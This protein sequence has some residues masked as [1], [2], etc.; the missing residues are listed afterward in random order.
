[1]TTDATP[2]TIKDNLTKYGLVALYNDQD[3]LMSTYIQIA[4]SYKTSKMTAGNFSATAVACMIARKVLYFKKT[5][6]DCPLKTSYSFGP[7]A[8]VSKAAGIAGL[9]LETAA[10]GTALATTGGVSISAAGGVAVGLATAAS[11]VGLAALPFT[12]WAAFSA[13]HAAAVAKEQE[14]I[15]EILSAVNPSFDQIDTAVG[16]GS[17]A[18]ADAIK[19]LEQMRVQATNALKNSGIYQN[20]NAACYII[21]YLNCVTDLRELL[22]KQT[23]DVSGGGLA[24]SATSVAN[25]LSQTNGVVGIGLAA[26]AAKAGGLI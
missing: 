11:I 15:C 7:G 17:V 3:P 1:M 16:N 22:Y 20:C 9:G 2:Q 14:T 5:P 12:I 10:T 19:G 21:G 13:H 8:T 23:A 26:L 24:P 4:H 18:A 6:G 25:S